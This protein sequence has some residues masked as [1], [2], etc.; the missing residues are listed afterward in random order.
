VMDSSSDRARRQAL[1]KG[2]GHGGWGV[3]VLS[4]RAALMG[5]YV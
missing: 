2:T 3:M 1:L 4:V 5:L